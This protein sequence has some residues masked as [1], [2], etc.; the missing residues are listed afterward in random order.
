MT[1]RYLG[2]GEVIRLQDALIR[3]SGGAQGLRDLA[4]LESAVA[5]PQQTFEGRDLHATIPQ[6]AAALGY[7]LILNHGFLDGNKRIGHAAMEVFLLLNGYEFQADV[8]DA[9]STILA[10]A[11]GSMTRADLTDWVSKHISPC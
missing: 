9:E 3:Q 11:S 1:V 5:Q 2:L 4:A 10:V 6:K 7:S 8:N